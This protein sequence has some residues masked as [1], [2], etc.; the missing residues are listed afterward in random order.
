MNDKKTTPPITTAQP[1]VSEQIEKALMG[2]D[3]SSLSV[4]QRLSYYNA[5]CESLGLNPLTKPFDFMKN[6]AGGLI[7]YA[8]KN[9]TDQLRQTRAVNLAVVARERHDQLFT[10]TVRATM[11][12]GRTDESIGA[13]ELS[14]KRGE[15][16]ANAVMKAE[17]KAKRRVT[18]SICGLGA[19]DE[20]EVVDNPGLFTQTTINEPVAQMPQITALVTPVSPQIVVVDPNTAQAAPQEQAQQIGG[21]YRYKPDYNL[22]DAF[23]AAARAANVNPKWDGGAKEWITTGPVPNFASAIVFSPALTEP[24][25]DDENQAPEYTDA[26][27]MGVES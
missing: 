22:K 9:C 15:D 20:S 19:L 10:V 5:V 1:M 14:G 12:N 3:L 11:P 25:I 17:T 2:G 18:L 16:L 21:E 4:E 7:M 8:N 23:K 13:T 24:H 26:D 6:K 27:L